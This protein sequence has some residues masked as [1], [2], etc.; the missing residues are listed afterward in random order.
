MATSR[1]VWTLMA[2]SRCTCSST[3]GRQRGLFKHLIQVVDTHRKAEQ[4]M[5]VTEGKEMNDVTVFKNRAHQC[6][7][8]G[9]WL[10]LVLN[11]ECLTGQLVVKRHG[12]PQG[13][14]A[15]IC[16]RSPSVTESYDIFWQM[17]RINHCPYFTSRGLS[18]D[19]LQSWKKQ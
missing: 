1:I 5:F 16:S 15:K 9:F 14:E 17:T 11:T 3:C 19:R 6:W 18:L 10:Q 13:A 4:K 8:L 2:P 12:E 7:S